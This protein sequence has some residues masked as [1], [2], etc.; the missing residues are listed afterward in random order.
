M[1]NNATLNFLH[2]DNRLTGTNYLEWKRKLILIL[3]AEKIHHVISTNGSPLP[4]T[5]EGDDYVAWETFKEKDTL[6]IAYILNSIDKNLQSSCDDLESAK[7]VMEHLEQ[8]FGKKD[9]LA[10]QQISSVLFSTKM[11]DSTTI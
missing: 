9:R 10:R 6:A 11:H 2:N 5:T 4:H 1:T 8:T 3:K 7:D